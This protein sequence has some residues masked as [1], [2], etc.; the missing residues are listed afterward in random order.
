MDQSVVHGPAPQRGRR[1]AAWLL[2]GWAMFWLVTMMPWCGTDLGGFLA[3]ASQHVVA[4]DGIR[5]ASLHDNLPVHE[6]CHSAVSDALMYR[7]SVASSG[8][9][10]FKSAPGSALAPSPLSS[11]FHPKE[12]IWRAASVAPLSGTES[13]L[14][15]RR[16]LI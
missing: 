15:H 16:L 2:L 9:D 4:D 12:V 3:T 5:S 7:F 8:T 10:I 11:A 14:R 13:Y 1:L 6:D